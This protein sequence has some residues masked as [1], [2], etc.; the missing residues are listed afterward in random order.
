SPA[1]RPGLVG[2]GDVSSALWDGA[3]DRVY[4]VRHA[5][6]VV[7]AAQYK[8]EIA[9]YTSATT[10]GTAVLLES[11]AAQPVRKLVVASSMCVYGEGMYRDEAGREVEPAERTR[12]Q[13]ARQE[14]EYP[15]L[16]PMPTPERKRPGLASIY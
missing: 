7:A 1:A 5:A 8:Y 12:K 9:E 16:E 2:R 6:A 15:G 13:L 4:S 14:W 3:L 10:L 11:L